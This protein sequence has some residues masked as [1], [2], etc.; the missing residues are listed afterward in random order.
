[1]TLELPVRK[2][3]QVGRERILP[4]LTAIAASLA[5]IDKRL[6]RLEARPPTRIEKIRE[7]KPNHRRLV[8]GGTPIHRQRRN[9]K[10]IAPTIKRIR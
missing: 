1:M 7:W 10:K 6:A 9:V 3:G 8:D 2:P 5:S 4:V